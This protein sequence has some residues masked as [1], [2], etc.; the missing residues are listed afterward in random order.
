VDIVG[1]IDPVEPEAVN[2]S[3]E[4][5]ERKFAAGRE[6]YQATWDEILS[7]PVPDRMDDAI[8]ARIVY[9]F[10]LAAKAKP[11]DTPRYVGAPVP[12]YFARVASFIAEAKDLDTERAEALVERQAATFERLKPELIAR[13]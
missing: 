4:I 2:A 13:W 12:Q 1:S 7:E 11:D 9:D 5:L 8:W 6:Q 3:V 10:L